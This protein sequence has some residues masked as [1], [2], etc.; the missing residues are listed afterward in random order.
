MVVLSTAFLPGLEYFALMLKDY[1]EGE[2]CVVEIESCESFVKQTYRNRFYYLSAAGKEYLNIPL[3][4]GTS[5]LITDIEVDYS[6]PW[7]QKAIRALETAYRTAPFFD[8]YSEEL[9]DILRSGEVKLFDLNFRILLWMIRAMRLPVELRV[10][11]DFHKELPEGYEDYRD[12]SPKKP[13]TILRDLGLEKE[14]F[15]VFSPRFGFTHGLSALDLLFNEG[16]SAWE[17]IFKPTLQ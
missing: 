9:F 15:Q 5:R 2:K 4:H 14:Y 11:T 3:S 1:K 13:N 16:P 8:Y 6:T 12:L 7:V 10:T 17:Y